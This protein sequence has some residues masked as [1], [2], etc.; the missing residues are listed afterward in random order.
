MQAVIMAGGFGTRLRPL[1]I[2]KPKPMV[3]LMNKP[4]IGHI[5]SLLQKHSITDVVVML[6][7]QPDLIKNYLGDGSKFGL[8]C[9]YLLPEDD[10]GTAGSVKFA[11]SYIDDTFLVISGDLLTDVDLT[12]FYSFHIKKKS[13]A[14]ILLTREPDPLQFGIVMTNKRHRITNFYEKPSW[15]EVFSDWINSGIY[16]FERK[17]LDLLPSNKEYDFGKD[18]F[19]HLLNTRHRFF[20]YPGE[21]YWKDIGNLEEYLAVHQDCLAGK[22][23][24]T[25]DGK[26][27]ENIIKGK[28]SS[29][30]LTAELAGNIVL[31]NNVTIEEGAYVHNAVIGNNTLIKKRRG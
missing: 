20:S 21:C 10:L 14:T 13:D 30:A 28:R 3:P 18:L 8:K 26:R 2:Y 16:L 15:G 31:G 4:I 22:V 23:E 12:D 9:T 1:T 25:I 17:M 24:F 19:P 11:E 5:A 6:Y 27:N 7:H 29:I